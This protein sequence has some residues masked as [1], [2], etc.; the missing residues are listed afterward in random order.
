MLFLKGKA[1]LLLT[2]SQ[3]MGVVN[4]R[5]LIKNYICSNSIYLLAISSSKNSPCQNEV[6]RKSFPLKTSSICMRIKSDFHIHGS[7]LSLACKQ[8]LVKYK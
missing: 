1:S 3:R 2:L 7:A 5:R 6:R 4:Y 8:M